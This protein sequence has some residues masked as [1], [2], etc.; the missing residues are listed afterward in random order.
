MRDFHA[1]S[2]VPVFLTQEREGS[3]V[4]GGV[5]AQASR[6]PRSSTDEVLEY[7]ILEY[8][9]PKAGK[10]RKIQTVIILILLSCTYTGP[11]AT[12]KLELFY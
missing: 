7:R 5:S 6:T 9:D 11:Y 8:P 1:S 2:T 4:E 12:R 10:E 3:D